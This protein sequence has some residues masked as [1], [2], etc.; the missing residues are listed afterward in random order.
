MRFQ[1]LVGGKG[2]EPSES[3]AFEAV[4]FASLRYPPEPASYHTLPV[5]RPMIC[6]SLSFG[7]HSLHGRPLYRLVPLHRGH[8]TSGI[9]S[10][11]DAARSG[12]GGA[13]P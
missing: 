7:E 10:L 8:V 9:S 4:S 12:H 1:S 13:L 6:P 11:L 3:T 2:V 5:G